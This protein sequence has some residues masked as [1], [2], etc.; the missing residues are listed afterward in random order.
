MTT[1]TS[2]DKQTVQTGSDQPEVELHKLISIQTVED[3]LGRV[4]NEQFSRLVGIGLRYPLS[5]AS[6]LKT[7]LLGGLLLFPL[8]VVLLTFALGQSILAMFHFHIPLPYGT[9]YE[10][11]LT[12]IQ[13]WYVLA[14]LS[15][16][17]IGSFIYTVHRAVGGES[18][19]KSFP[20]YTDTAEWTKLCIVGLKGS[21]ILVACLFAPLAFV[22][23]FLGG[24]LGASVSLGINQTLAGYLPIIGLL[25][26]IGAYPGILGAF[27]QHGKV[28][29]A[30]STP[31][32]SILMSR[33]YLRCVAAILVLVTATASLVHV[34]LGVFDQEVN[35]FSDAFEVFLLFFVAVL[36]YCAL[37]A[38]HYV[39][40]VTWRERPEDDDLSDAVPAIPLLSDRSPRVD[41]LADRLGPSTDFDLND[42]V[43]WEPRSRLDRLTVRFFRGIKKRP[44]IIPSMYLVVLSLLLLFSTLDNA[45]QWMHF[46]YYL[47]SLVPA[48]FL[49]ALVYFRYRTKQTP[50]PTLVPV[51]ILGAAFAPIASQL[52]A[53][54]DAIRAIGFVGFTI[55]TVFVSIPVLV[56]GSLLA[57]GLA[58]Y[59][60]RNFT[61]VIDGAIFGAVAGLGF[62]V[63]RQAIVFGGYTEMATV[64]SALVETAFAPIH[65]LLIGLGGYYLGL[66]KFNKENA[67]PILLKGILLVS[68]V[69]AAI[70]ILTQLIFSQFYQ[71]IFPQQVQQASIT[72]PVANLEIWGPTVATMLFY[73]L[74][75]SIVGI[76]LYRKL[77][78]YSRLV[79]LASDISSDEDVPSEHEA[80]VARALERRRELQKLVDHGLISE[81]E[82]E[83]LAS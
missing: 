51:F 37:S 1:P 23:N 41:P 56:L 78:V 64:H 7:I 67:G 53:Y 21:V 42:I 33:R 35:V 55:Y 77:S 39:I 82:F 50:L 46:R 5:N 48:V 83:D 40:G 45:F 43:T 66:A 13:A 14:V 68:T 81:R 20:H 34:S 38:I 3:A 18:E 27:V 15:V 17:V 71:Q 32:K 19:L 4:L 12:S 52:I 8:T 72:I 79:K 54:F 31:K 36:I 75:L 57:V 58:T 49:T 74:W 60:S 6:S 44:Y 63:I 30:V 22:S 28:R 73:L 2:P 65:V 70:I 29:E 76:M 25:V 24:E 16:P 80:E 59:R 10:V 11:N 9:G 26:I 62:I 47:Y 61:N 69:Y